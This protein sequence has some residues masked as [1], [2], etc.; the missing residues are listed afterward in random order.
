LYKNHDLQKMSN[1]KDI[2][3]QLFQQV[4]S[5]LPAH[6]SVVDEIAELLQMSTD[7]AYRRIR[8]EKMLTLD[9]MAV[10]CSKY[11]LSV[12]GLLHLNGNSI[13]FAGQQIDFSRFELEQHLRFIL[14]Q[15]QQL[16]SF[17]NCRMYYLAKDVPVFHY[18]HFTN[19]AAFKFFAWLKTI[20]HNPV[21]NNKKFILSDA[22]NDNWRMLSHSIIDTYN[23]IP[24]EEIWS[25]ETI[26]S[27]IRQIEYCRDAMLFDS[28]ETIQLLYA[29]LLQLVNHIEEQAAA[30]CKFAPGSQGKN[31]GGFQLYY[32]GAILGD[33]TILMH[34][35][36]SRKV[37]LNHAILNYINTGDEKFCNYTA[38]SIDTIIQ[39]SALISRVGEKERNKFFNVLR[40]EVEMRMA[41]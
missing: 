14:L 1:P 23:R 16:Q 13:V 9:E 29:E 12:D 18:F 37:Y 2:Q 25:L 15:L 11:Q 17:S 20:L 4:K 35:G 3:Q 7:S 22:V 26:N 30:G 21:Y 39:K 19:L 38:G 34:M 27:T 8:G 41:K 28:E 31:G 32:N 36:E 24:S 5:A 10:L 33:N 40:S 6:V